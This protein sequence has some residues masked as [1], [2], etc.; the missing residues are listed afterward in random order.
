[1]DYVSA[2]SF[3]DQADQTL[4]I[5]MGLTSAS[6]LGSVTSFTVTGQGANIPFGDTNPNPGDGTNF[7]G[8]PVTSGFRDRTFVITNTGTGPINLVPG[9]RGFLSISGPQGPEFV[10]IQQPSATIAPGESSTFIIRLDPA[11]SGFRNA[12][13]SFATDDN[14][15]HPFTFAVRG[16]GLITG[17]IRVRGGAAHGV[18]VNNATSPLNSNG[19]RFGQKV[20]AGNAS[21]TRTFVISNIGAGSLALHGSPL[22]TISGPNAADFSL[23][24]APA[25]TV[26]H[27]ATTT[28]K[29]KFNPTD[30]GIRTA[31]ITILTNDPANPTFTFTIVGTGN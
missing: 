25:R 21:V 14:T 30:L 20:A 24:L 17:A 16:N 10:V 5:N 26:A 29:I 28:F 15:A 6:R 13:V 12:T 1:M 7:A 19:T 2:L 8:I 11:G 4:L 3:S 9:S 31:T 18:I 22:I 23:T 27:G